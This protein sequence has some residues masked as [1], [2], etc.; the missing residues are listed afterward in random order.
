[1]LKL[2]L[3]LRCLGT[4][5]C[6]QRAGWNGGARCELSFT[7]RASDAAFQPQFA[8]R[9][10][11]LLFLGTIHLLCPAAEAQSLGKIEFNQDIRPILAENCFYCHGQ[12][13]N[14]RKADLRLDVREAAVEFGA[15]VPG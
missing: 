13:P 4:S 2:T 14:K 9:R 5:V 1:M 3:F 6:Q 15:F 11:A 7:K 12:D 10:A 8:R